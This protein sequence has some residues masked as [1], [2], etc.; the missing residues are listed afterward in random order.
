MENQGG[1]MPDI[2][3]KSYCWSIGTTSFRVKDLNYKIEKQLQLLNILWNENPNKNWQELQASYYKILKENGLVTGNASRMDKDA[4]Q[5]TSGLVNIGVID[6]ERKITEVGYEILTISENN[7]FS[8]DNI[9]NLPKDSYIYLMQFLKYTINDIQFKTKPFI[10]LIYLLSKFDFLSI[11][12]FTYLLP[13]CIN[14]KATKK[15]CFDINDLRN[16]S[17][18]IDQILIKKMWEMQ[19]YQDAFEYFNSCSTLTEEDFEIIGMN[20]KSKRYDRSYKKVFDKIVLIRDEINHNGYK[21]HNLLILYEDLLDAISKISLSRKWNF[22]FIGTISKS[23]LLKNIDEVE[24]KIQSIDLF[25]INEEIFKKR[26]FEYLHLLKWKATLEDYQDLNKRYFSLTDVLVYDNDRV[27]LDYFPHYYFK[28]IAEKLLFEDNYAKLNK[29]FEKKVSLNGI[30]RFL[31]DDINR[32]LQKINEAE[33]ISLSKCEVYDYIKNQKQKKLKDLL[34][35][36][37]TRE[38]IEHIIDLIEKRK[39]KQ[40]L[41]LVTDNA[42]IP[43]IFEYVIALAWFHIS[44]F[45]VDFIESIKTNLDSNLLPRSH[46][47]GGSA[48]IV[49]KYNETDEYPSHDLLIEATLTES[50]NQRRTEMEP[51]SRH[52]GEYLGKYDNENDYAVFIAP[53]IHK[54]VAVD[55]RNRKTMPYYVDD[56]KQI[57]GMKIIPLGSSQVRKYLRS[58]K[59]Y[60]EIYQKFEQAYHSTD[61]TYSWYENEVID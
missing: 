61:L 26:F 4:R 21:S 44:D 29:C 12:E 3:F 30:S 53:F 47:V 55:F 5:V 37:F 25:T 35:T 13:L 19:N 41:K 46:A 23:N 17:I 57:D 36:R 52:L 11:D 59:K 8:P 10:S 42:D 15:I 45:S 39:D 34:A 2:S 7:D 51:V 32:V 9:F 27:S 28:E 18:T 33:G 38:N 24:K 56:G 50:K 16:G 48:D 6:S 60:Y 1:T 43:T 22:I 31:T 54:Q 14:E 49:F 40:V 58:N 20:R